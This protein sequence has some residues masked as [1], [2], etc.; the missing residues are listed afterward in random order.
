MTQLTI[1]QS[2]LLLVSGK[3]KGSRGEGSR[4]GMCGIQQNKECGHFPSQLLHC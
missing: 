1:T 3:K 4:Y 2:L